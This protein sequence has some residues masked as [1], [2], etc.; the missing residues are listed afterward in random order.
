M[1]RKR[2]KGAG[3]DEAETPPSG[4]APPKMT[5]TLSGDPDSVKAQLGV[6]GGGKDPSPE[7]VEAKF[8][9]VIKDPKNGLVVHRISPRKWEG[10][11][12]NVEVYRERCPLTLTQVEEEVFGEHG[13]KDYRFSVVDQETGETI[14]ACIRRHGGDPIIPETIES[15][16]GSFLREVEQQEDP[17][18]QSEKAL[19]RRIRMAGLRR[20]LEV[21]EGTGR[22]TDNGNED[23]AAT[24][25]V[26][27]LEKKITDIQ[28]ESKFDRMQREHREEM[29]VL[30]DKIDKLQAPKPDGDNKLLEMMIKQMESTQKSTNDQ[31][32]RMMDQMKDD[33]LVAIERQLTA[34]QNKPATK[35]GG[36]VESIEMLTKVAGLLGMDLPGAGKDDA[37]DER[38]WYERLMDDHLPKILD[39]IIEE[40]KEGGP[41]ISKEELAKRIA[42]E[43]D[44]AIAE[45]TARIAEK[46]RLAAEPPRTIKHEIDMPQPS[47]AAPPAPAP[48]PAVE[49]PAYGPPPADSAPAAPQP[50]PAPPAAPPKPEEPPP[51]SKVPSIEEEISQRCG[52]VLVVMSREMDLRPR[53]FKWTFIAWDHLPEVIREKLAKAPDPVAMFNAFDGYVNP[54]G[55]K[56]LKEKIAAEVKL[57]AWFARGLKEI[58]EWQAKLDADP[59]FDPS[60]EGEEPD[61]EEP[62]ASPGGET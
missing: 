2:T 11:K 29:R 40:K 39:A 19:Q 45:E 4:G 20:D 12:I 18:E 35:D 61:G 41:P 42:V 23:P 17:G 24:E 46:K 44:K 25:R 7:P 28:E 30:A 9:E 49:A 47:P 26:R 13:G 54:E 6:G 48:A 21:V 60:Q 57:T 15:V 16:D 38:P 3:G 53:D 62:G 5:A 10:R 58:G 27:E 22:R 1:A 51:T 36:M 33:K 32:N 14:A 59:N 52:Q 56:A 50:A 31:M 43:A 8:H 34:I 55:L 37:S